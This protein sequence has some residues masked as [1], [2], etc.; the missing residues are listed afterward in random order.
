M[1][2]TQES[3]KLRV[4]GWLLLAACAGLA[5]CAGPT[6]R[7]GF[8]LATEV[9]TSDWP[10]GGAGGAVLATS[11]YRL[12]TNTGNRTA[13]ECLPG[14]MERAREYY[15]ELTGL[16][17]T[18]ANAEPMPIY[19]LGDRQAWAAFTEQ[20]TGPQ[21]SV[22]LSIENGGYCYRDVCVLWDMGQFSTFSVA[23]HEGL[24][25]FL[26]RH[27]Q[28]SIPAWAEEGLCTQMEGYDLGAR[29]VRFDAEQNLGRMTTLREA[30][31]N[32]RWVP[33]RTLLPYDAGD[34]VARGQQAPECYAQLWALILFIRSEP[35]YRAGLERLLADAAAGRLHA[36]L[37]TSAGGRE[38]NQAVALPVFERYID[39]DLRLFE[40]RYRQYAEKLARL[41]P[42]KQDV[43]RIW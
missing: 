27:L 12:Y 19:F 35:N 32:G 34:F 38:Y 26:H 1:P 37:P 21:S 4:G 6:A 15:V 36:A 14:F 29:T 20:I 16:R 33:L 13:R 28:D 2:M 41:T 7:P 8:S 5:S 31:A 9:R 23:A 40:R 24:H 11:H 17:D 39:S 10:A 3:K 43:W 25:Q 18:A 30:L 22:F 42:V